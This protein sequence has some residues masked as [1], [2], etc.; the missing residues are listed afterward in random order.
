MKELQQRFFKSKG[1]YDWI[2][3]WIVENL[4]NQWEIIDIGPEY[5]LYDSIG[6]RGAAIENGELIVEDL[7]Q[8]TFE[9]YIEFCQDRILNALPVAKTFKEFSFTVKIDLSQELSRYQRSSYEKL[10]GE[11]DFYHST[12]SICEIN[13]APTTLLVESS[14]DANLIDVISRVESPTKLDDIVEE[15]I[16]PK[17]HPE[18]S[19]REFQQLSIF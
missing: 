6:K 1:E 18:E 5:R 13:D 9:G 11:Y 7:S 2:Y 17:L 4:T 16:L 8:H 3:I 14:I 10:I 12:E 19:I 15:L